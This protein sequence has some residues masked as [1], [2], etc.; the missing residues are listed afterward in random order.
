M[1]I[2]ASQSTG[3][4]WPLMISCPCGVCIQLLEAR[5]QKVETSV[6]MATITVAKKCKPRPTRFQPNSMTPRKP[7]SRKNAVSTS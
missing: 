6:P 7:A 3:I 4:T 1:K 5:I 2:T